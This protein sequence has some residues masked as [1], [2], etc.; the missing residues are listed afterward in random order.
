M[1]NTYDIS[2]IL[3]FEKGFPADLLIRCIQL[4]EQAVYNSELM[5]LKLLFEE[6]VNL[7]DMPSNKAEDLFHKMQDDLAQYKGQTLRIEGASKGSLL[8]AGVV[9]SIASPLIMLTF[10]E[11][12][13][14]AWKKTKL[15]KKIEDVLLWTWKGKV[16]DI[17]KNIESSARDDDKLISNGV[18][19][20]VKAHKDIGENK[21]NVKIVVQISLPANREA[22]PTYGENMN[23]IIEYI[24][25]NQ[26]DRKD[27]GPSSSHNSGR[28]RIKH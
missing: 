6:T 5:E 15:Y 1:L 28:G 24:D 2:V 13:K 23:K 11:S 22:L 9:I 14:D 7:F 8:L 20:E 3:R 18:I 27:E 26:R 16:E 12:I 19:A 25:L 10:G 17:G 21:L 4:V